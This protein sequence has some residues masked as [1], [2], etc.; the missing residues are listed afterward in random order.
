MESKGR[1]VTMRECVWK[2]QVNHVSDIQT[3][4]PRILKKDTQTTLL[5]AIRDNVVFGFVVCDVKTP[6][7]II[8]E[9]EAAGFL[10]PPIIKRMVIEDCHLSPFMREKFLSEE[11]KLSSKST[12]QFFKINENLSDEQLYKIDFSGP[13]LQ[14]RTDFCPD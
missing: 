7:S 2:K 14:R 13:D 12:G 11:R 8:K 6:I 4:I 10:F 1:L 3:K 5:N 9:R